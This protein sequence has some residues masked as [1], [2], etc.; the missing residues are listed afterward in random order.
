MVLLVIKMLL[1]VLGCK[2]AVSYIIKFVNYLILLNTLNGNIAPY[3]RGIPSYTTELVG[4]QA[5][6]S[7]PKIF[8]IHG[9]TDVTLEKTP[10]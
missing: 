4:K 6:R 1:W 3:Q 2:K 10:G 9:R 7:G 8:L 5:F